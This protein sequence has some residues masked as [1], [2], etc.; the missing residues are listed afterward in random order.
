MVVPFL[1]FCV[2]FCR[3]SRIKYKSNLYCFS[4][5]I[6]CF[7]KVMQCQVNNNRIVT[8]NRH[9][10]FCQETADSLCIFPI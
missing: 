1:I 9:L 7:R 4:A 8:Y 2:P 6:V 5:N 10:F 3:L